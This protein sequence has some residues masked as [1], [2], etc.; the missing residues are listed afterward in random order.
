MAK[1]LIVDDDAFIRRL[2]RMKVE[3]LGHLVE[4]AGDGEEG[5]RQAVQV[6]PDLICS[7]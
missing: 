7:T 1:V 4:E 3:Q 5:L 2:V 6:G